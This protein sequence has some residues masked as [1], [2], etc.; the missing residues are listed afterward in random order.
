MVFAH[1]E[2]L[3]KHKKGRVLA[4]DIKTGVAEVIAQNIAF[5]NGIAFE[6]HTQSVLFS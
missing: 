3:V 5:A 1:K 4:Y 6:A 2:I